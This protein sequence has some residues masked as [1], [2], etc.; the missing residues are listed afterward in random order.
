MPLYIAASES[1]NFLYIYQVFV[2]L[3][4]M[5]W[6]LGIHKQAAERWP[7]ASDPDGMIIGMLL[8]SLT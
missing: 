3:S 8:S 7:T 4:R 1:D 6:Y 5:P 2:T